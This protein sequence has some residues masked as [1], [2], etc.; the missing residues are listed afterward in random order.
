MP[1]TQNALAALL[2]DLLARDELDSL[3]AINNG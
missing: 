3:E 1:R 2:R